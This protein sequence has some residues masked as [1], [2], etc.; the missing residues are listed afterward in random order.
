MYIHERIPKKDVVNLD[1]TLESAEILKRD[2]TN[3]NCYE[4][5]ERN[6]KQLS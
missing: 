1:R 4:T 3:A 2:Q 6:K 5:S